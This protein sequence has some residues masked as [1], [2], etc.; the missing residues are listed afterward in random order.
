MT[1]ENGATE[2]A[3][4]TAHEIANVLSYS[5]SF[6]EDHDVVVNRED[7]SVAISM[8]PADDEVVITAQVNAEGQMTGLSSHPLD[9]HDTE[10]LRDSVLWEDIVDEGISVAE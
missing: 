2:A 10:N 4:S 1:L 9:S 7:G 5:T 8:W 6:T 3:Y